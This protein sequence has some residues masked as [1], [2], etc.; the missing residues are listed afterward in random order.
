MKSVRK[1]KK[2]S[3]IDIAFKI[4]LMIFCG[5]ITIFASKC[6]D[7]WAKYVVTDTSKEVINAN[8]FYFTSN[9]L[10]PVEGDNTISEYILFGWDG[11]SKKSFAFNIRNYDNP[12][13]YNNES[14]NINYEI[15]Y[16]VL[17][18]DEEYI[19]AKVYR[20]EGD[21]ENESLGGNLSGGSDSY[22]AHEYKLSITSKND[23]VAINH[24][25]TILLK[26]KTIDSPYYAELQTK[27]TLQYT[28]FENFI[29]YQG[30]DSEDN[31]E[32]VSALKFN[33]NT[34]NQIDESEMENTDITIATETI[35]LSWNN[36]LVELNGFDKKILSRTNIKT[37]EEVLSE[38]DNAYQCK[39][40]IIIDENTNIGHI[41][42]DAL[43]YS[44]YEIV[45]YK[46]VAVAGNE[47]VWKN[48]NNEYIWN[49]TPLKISEGGLVYAETVKK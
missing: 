9:Y 3:I 24:D 5:F 25:V 22:T 33:I 37:L 49:V 30:F 14:Q 38:Y 8:S 44:A 16:E 4:T 11:K 46:R 13:L 20:I 42:F 45:F 43:A 26:A 28:S 34:A 18:G 15:S 41:Y 36:N 35:H 40:T 7:A 21:N 47:D 2:E 17:N 19:D 6:Y 10:N 29:A 32:K 31:N 48:S 39:N 23:S 12:L 27:V 1:S